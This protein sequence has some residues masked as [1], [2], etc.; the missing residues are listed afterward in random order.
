M[1]VCGNKGPLLC[2]HLWDQKQPQQLEHS[3]QDLGRRVLFAPLAST[4]AVCALLQEH[5]TGWGWGWG[6]VASVD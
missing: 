3:P 1:G 5:G 6:M 4:Q 2:L